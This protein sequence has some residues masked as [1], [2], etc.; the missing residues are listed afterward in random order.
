MHLQI[1]KKK[2]LFLYFFLLLFLTTFH[3]LKFYNYDFINLSIKNVDVFGLSKDENFK[4]SKKI[5][6]DISKN[7]LF[8]N[9]D[10][11]NN[12]F[13]KNSLV[14]SFEIKK[15]YPN[16][17]EINIKKTK[18]IAIVEIKGDKFFVGSNKKL[19]K[20]KNIN[21]NLPNIYDNVNIDDFI[22]LKKEID[23]SKLDFNIISDLYFFPSGRWDIKIKKNVL[24]K[25]PKKNLSNTLDLVSLIIS[26]KKFKDNKIIDMRVKNLII[27]KNE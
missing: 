7:I 18:F 8:L 12:F 17:L 13:K 20:Y 15:I 1:D 25:L 27:S 6:R 2:K 26:D 16:S 22:K 21:K 10:Y 23:N 3:N 4:I 24:I 9:K 19:T 5:T 14:D 11:F